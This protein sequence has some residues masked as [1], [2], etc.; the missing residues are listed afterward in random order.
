MN[1]K[2]LALMGLLGATF[3]AGMVATYEE[4]AGQPL[5]P[6]QPAPRPSPPPQQVE[7]APDAAPAGPAFTLAPLPAGSTPP[8][9]T[10]PASWIT[11]DDY[12]AEALRNNWQGTVSIRWTI[13]T[14]GLVENC[15][16]LQTS[17]HAVLDEAACQAIQSR[18]RYVPAM[19]SQGHAIA[20]E[21]M[22]RVVWRLPE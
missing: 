11:S 14:T 7:R 17:G 6:A 2:A 3:V 15:R 22:R 13:G 4:E 20:S 18:A 21:D 1:W 8:Q 10:E 5:A 9:A 19:N 16:V 12:P